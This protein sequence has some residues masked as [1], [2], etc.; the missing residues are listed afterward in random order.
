[1]NQIWNI[2]TYDLPRKAAQGDM[3]AAAGISAALVANAYTMFILNNRRNP[4]EEEIME[5]NPLKQGLFTDQAMNVLPLVGRYVVGARQGF[6]AELPV[7]KA[8]ADPIKRLTAVVNSDK[9]MTS[10]EFNALVFDIAKGT[11]PLHG[12]PLTSGERAYKTI[13]EGN[14]SHLLGV[15]KEEKK[16]RYIKK[17]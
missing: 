15:R 7:M 10:E 6:G 3:A 8:V 14:P 2:A 17:N 4:T 9:K 13:Q 5:T 12:I 16:K 11:T 1:M